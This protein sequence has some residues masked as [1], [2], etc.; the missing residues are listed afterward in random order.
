MYS[1]VLT[2]GVRSGSKGFV[3]EAYMRRGEVY[4]RRSNWKQATADLTHS[5]TIFTE[6]KRLESL[7]RVEN[8][9]GTNYAEQGK[10]KQAV[11]FFERA[12]AL[13]ERT[14]Q[15]Q[16]A[17]VA[18]MNLGITSNITGRYDSALAYYKRAQSCFEEV[19]D[20]NR[21]AEL[22]HNTGMS[23][24][25]K[26]LY[27]GAIR[28]F[29]TSLSLSSSTQNVPLTGLANL[30]K[31]NAYF[32]LRD[33]PVA[34]KLVNAAI[35]AFTRA[36]ERLGLADSYK[37][38]GMIHREMKSMDA[39]ASYLQTSL[40]MNVEINNQL[41]IAESNFEI[42]VLE[43]ERRRKEDALRAFQKAISVFRKVGADEEVQRTRQY[44]TSLEGGKQ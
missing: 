7:A 29:N 3:A 25:S 22:H 11:D 30:A 32:H 2:Q 44:I 28:E 17:G 14:Q 4:S 13:F 37:M 20:L 35:D 5:K 26:K 15:T 41:N 39:A 12:L 6:L 34:L 24:L 27:E 43:M 1:M 19:G 16:M 33:L 23:Y 10:I 9:L 42:G 38:K 40:R 21:L 36:N 31:A 8:I 18:L